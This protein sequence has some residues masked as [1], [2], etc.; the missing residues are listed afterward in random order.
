MDYLPPINF[1]P[2][3]HSTNGHHS[4][5]S[6]VPDQRGPVQDDTMTDQ[7]EGAIQFESAER[8]DDFANMGLKPELLRGIYALGLEYPSYIQ[9]R[10]I[11]PITRGNV[12]ACFK[13]LL[14]QL[15]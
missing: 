3:G 8:F 2:A 5:P 11:V 15:S 4:E 10:A 7:D 9:E 13:F 14:T 12:I 6:N 1:H